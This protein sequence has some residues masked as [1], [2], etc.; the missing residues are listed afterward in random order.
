MGWTPHVALAYN[1]IDQSSTGFTPFFLAH[2][3]E[4]RV[5]LDLLF[6][7]GSSV[8]SATN[9]TPTAFANSLRH[10]LSAAYRSAT[11]FR[12]K[13]QEQ[14]RHYYDRHVRYTLYK[15]GDLVLTDNP[16]NKHN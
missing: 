14:Q 2:G 10:R 9:G 4:A 16:A 8:N 12:D 3:H 15:A 7:D 6:T 5:P 13:A 11:A 1:T